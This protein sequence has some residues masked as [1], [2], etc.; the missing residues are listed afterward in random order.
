[1]APEQ[2]GGEAGRVGPAAD[3]Y[4]LGV[5]LYELLT[6]RTPF[7][8]DSALEVLLRVRTEEPLSPSRLRR[9]VPRDLETICLKCLQ[10]EPAKRYARASDLVEDL[11]RFLAGEPIRARPVRAWERVVKWARR[12][13][14]IA[15]LLGSIILVTASGFA[16]VVWQWREADAARREVAEKADT[17]E[18]NLYY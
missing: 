1:M 10:K 8:G 6:G 5:I 18:T 3:I 13:P 15:A 4:A 7:Q 14:A 9:K 12:R 11:R 17:L 16:G 2:A